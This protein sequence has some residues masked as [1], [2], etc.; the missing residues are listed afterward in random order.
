MR[1]AC[2]VKAGRRVLLTPPLSLEVTRKVP[3]FASRDF[4]CTRIILPASPPLN[5]FNG[6]LLYLSDYT[7]FPAKAVTATVTI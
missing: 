2:G 4:L 7:H 6:P 1:T 3:A 5:D